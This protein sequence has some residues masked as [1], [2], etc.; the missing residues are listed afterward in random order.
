MITE[1]GKAF[2]MGGTYRVPV[3]MNLLPKTFLNDLKRDSTFNEA[4]F[5]REYCSKWTGSVEDAFFDG[6]K[7]DR[8]RILLQPEN[9]Y[10]GRSSDRAYYVLGVDVGRVGCQTVIT[11]VKV[12][13]QV[14]GS[15]IKNLVNIFAFTEKHFEDQAI[16][17]KKLYYK[18]KARRVVID[19]MGLIISS[20]Y[21]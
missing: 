3:L 13:P 10:S 1:P 4:G 5:E 18:Y 21:K 12:T 2:I 16:Q 17:I 15:S 7:F 14:D 6:E 19:G 9:E 11:V 8:N 20:I